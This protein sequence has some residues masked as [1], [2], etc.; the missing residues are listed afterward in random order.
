M[1]SLLITYYVNTCILIY[2]FRTY[3]FLKLTSS[4]TLK[5]ISFK[6]TISL[7]EH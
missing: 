7:K 1:Y 2:I 4:L 3:S 5:T 6:R